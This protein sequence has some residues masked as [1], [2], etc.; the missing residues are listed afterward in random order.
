MIS[1]ES[2]DKLNYSDR[3]DKAIDIIKECNQDNKELMMSLGDYGDVIVELITQNNGD[4]IWL[5]IIDKPNIEI[6]LWPGDNS[7][8]LVDDNLWEYLFDFLDGLGGG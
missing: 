4:T 7:H 2:W 1:K 5:Q 6:N 3:L 8:P